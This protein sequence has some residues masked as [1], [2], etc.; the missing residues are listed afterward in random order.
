MA[1]ITTA[2]A[3]AKG[4][5]LQN[6]V[7][8]K[9]LE[10]HPAL[11]SDDVRGCPMGSSGADIQLSQAAKALIPFDVECK[12]RAKIGLV[13][14]ALA[15]AKRDPERTPLAIIKADRK[16]PLVVIDLDDFMAILTAI[17]IQ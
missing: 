17:H 13:Y 15:Q 16:K 4:R 14:D 3:K 7:R 11:T 9:L 8:D 6:L 1:R 2:S 10:L 12:A 5:N